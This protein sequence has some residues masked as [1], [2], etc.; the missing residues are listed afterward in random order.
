MTRAKRS[1][2]REAMNGALWRRCG[3]SAVKLR[4][5]RSSQAAAR[6]LRDRIQDAV[7]PAIAARYDHRQLPQLLPSC[8]VR[9]GVGGGSAAAPRRI[10]AMDEDWRRAL[11]RR[12]TKT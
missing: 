3:H 7:A 8:R 11:E 10:E 9:V 2:W 12:A 6:E 5:Y 1:V 4:S